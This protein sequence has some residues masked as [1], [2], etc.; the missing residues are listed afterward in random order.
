VNGTAEGRKEAQETQRESATPA[1]RRWRR[2]LILVNGL[3]LSRAPL[4]VVFGVC[5]VWQVFR[6]DAAWLA[7]AALAAL[8][9]AALT[10]AVDGWLARRWQVV[11][12]FGAMADPVTDKVFYLVTLPV[13]LYL[14]AHRNQSAHA[15]VMLVF[16]ILFMMR[17]QWVT[18]L[19]SV[20]AELGGDVQANWAGKL[21]TALSFPIACAVYVYVAWTPSWLPLG[22][23]YVLEAAGIAV[24]CLSIVVYTRQ[25]APYIVCSLKSGR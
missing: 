5:A 10:D 20:A 22:L 7:G 23:V 4:V 3:T 15:V 24:N 11:T 17:D 12:R 14:V 1:A 2:R 13:L 19:R 21:R 9:L 18:F 6:P 16:T 25:Y 8:I